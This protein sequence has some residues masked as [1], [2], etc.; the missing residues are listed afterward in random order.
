MASPRNLRKSGRKILDLPQVAVV[1]FDTRDMKKM[2]YVSVLNLSVQGVL[3]HADL[4]LKKNFELNLKILNRELH[5]W[6]MFY[7]RVAWLQKDPETGLFHIGL[8][9]LFPVENRDMNDTD[10]D[11]YVSSNELDFILNSRFVTPLPHNSICAFLNCLERKTV[12]GGTRLIDR[13]DGNDCFYIIQRG[14]CR[15]QFTEKDTAGQIPEI[16]GPGDVI[17]EMALLSEPLK[18]LQVTCESDM[19]LWELKNTAFDAACCRHPGLKNLLTELFINKVERS[20]AS[21]VRHIGRYTISRH[22]GAGS[23]SIVYKG[24]HRHLDLPVAIKMIIHSHTMSKAFINSFGKTGHQIQYLSHPNIVQILDIREQYRTL[25]ILMEYLDGESLDSIFKRRNNLPFQRILRI[26]LQAGSGLAHAHAHHIIHGNL[27]PANIYVLEHDHVKLLDFGLASSSTKIT[28]DQK[29]HA[30]YQSPEQAMGKI[31]DHRSD[32]YTFGL[33]ACELFTGRRIVENDPPEKDA[34]SPQTSGSTP[35]DLIR[36]CDLETPVKD[37]I[38]KACH[39]VPEKRFDS[40]KDLLDALLVLSDPVHSRPQKKT[41]TDKEVTVLLVSNDP[42]QRR[43]LHR[44]LD[45][46]SRNAAD[47]GLSVNIGGCPQVPRS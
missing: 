41:A 46:F 25:F 5:Q 14:Q 16:R 6:D 9:F 47:A 7:S 10:A 15:V 2:H 23:K 43:D 17:N 11:V 4:S 45:G 32:I 33:I 34:A 13:T 19:L 21:G 26:I 44:L 39:P 12:P 28:I 8:E 42:D 31:G 30:P 22:I 40:M 35:A 37:I 27:S 38:L 3:I 29:G 1:F 36:T 24:R 18:T 20:P